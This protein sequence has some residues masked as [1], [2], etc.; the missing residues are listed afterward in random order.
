MEAEVG[1]VEWSGRDAGA[2]FF[3]RGG[4]VDEDVFA[5]ERD[6]GMTKIMC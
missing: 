3:S 4:T 2:N 5:Q 6:S 1:E